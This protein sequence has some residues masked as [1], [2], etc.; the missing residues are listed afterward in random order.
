MRATPRAAVVDLDVHQG[1]GTALIFQDDPD[2]LTLSLHGRNNFPFRKQQSR[3]DV[4]L[5]DGASDAEYLAALDAVLPRVLAFAPEIIFYQSGV[6][7]LAGDKLGRLALTHAGLAARDRRVMS[8]AKAA[9]IPLVVTLGG[10]YAQPIARTALAHANTFRT[11]AE[12][13]G[14]RVATSPPVTSHAA[15]STPLSRP[16]PPVRTSPRSSR[17]PSAHRSAPSETGD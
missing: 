10:G 1:D 7:P 8:L 9:R 6:D 14:G 17:T 11:A 15:Q 16:A 5:P 4:D 2:V 3:I 13:W 12:V